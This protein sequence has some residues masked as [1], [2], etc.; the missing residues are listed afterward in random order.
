MFNGREHAKE[1]D[2]KILEYTNRNETKGRLAIILIGA[3]KSSEKYVSIKEKV[4]RRVGVSLQVYKFID[5]ESVEKVLTRGQ[6][7]IESK[8]VKSVIVQ[9]PLPDEKFNK[10]VEKIPPEK[11]VDMLSDTSKE[12]FYKGRILLISPVVRAIEYFINSNNLK[13][14]G[15]DALIV[16]YGE[17]VGKPLTFFLKNIGMNVEFTENY[18]TGDEI[19]KDLVILSAGV[20]NLVNGGDISSGCSVID[21]GS[22]I[23]NGKTVGDLNLNSKLDHLEIISPSPGGMGPLVVRFL[24]MNHLGI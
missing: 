14:N 7:I 8:D 6:E 5:T 4:A 18:K 24:L 17:L 16:G 23:L 1:L 12:N 22:F 21:F 11:D 15:K 19:N 2:Q 3:N 10:L 20:P 13:I 9:L